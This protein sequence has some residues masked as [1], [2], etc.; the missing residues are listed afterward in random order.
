V[1]NLYKENED[2]ERVPDERKVFYLLE[3][4]VLQAKRVVGFDKKTGEDQSRGQW[5][6]TPRLLRQSV[7]PVA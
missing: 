1:L 4:G 3:I 2:G 6:S 7:L 5:C